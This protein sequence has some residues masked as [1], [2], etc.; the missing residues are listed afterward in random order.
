[1]KVRELLQRK[2]STVVS[3]PPGTSVG[4]VVQLLLR[5]NIGAMPVVSADDKLLGI[6]GERDFL[7]S[8][9]L[10]GPRVQDMPVEQVMQRELPT[11]DASASLQELMGR[12]T[13]ERWRH[14]L[15]LEDGD[16]AGILSVGD[17]V[18]HRL[19]Q[20]ETETSILRDYV[21]AARAGV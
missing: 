8:F 3:T 9:Q 5:H 1:M 16:V 17:I 6:F 7:R 19:D 13:R 21:T 12:M 14:V 11:C 15:I 4:T 18:K 20:L 2:G 10:N